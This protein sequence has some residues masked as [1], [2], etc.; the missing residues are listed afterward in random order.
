VCLQ[1]PEGIAKESI[2]GRNGEYVLAGNAGKT[3]GDYWLK[4]VNNRK[5]YVLNFNKH[6]VV[7]YKHY[8]NGV[9]FNIISGETSLSAH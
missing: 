2:E 6:E 3:I 1:R 8:K 7:L 9:L 5:C 4:W